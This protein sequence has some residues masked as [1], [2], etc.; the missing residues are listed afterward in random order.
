MSGNLMDPFYAGVVFEII[1]YEFLIVRVSQ[2][3]INQ[4]GNNRKTAAG[5]VNPDGR[6]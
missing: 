5:L 6:V 2:T 1:N 3:V 4:H